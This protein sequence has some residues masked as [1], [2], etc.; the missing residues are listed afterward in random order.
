MSDPPEPEGLPDAAPWEA[1]ARAVLAHEG[2]PADAEVS[3]RFVDE[4]EMA[5]LNATHLGQQGPTDVLSFPVDLVGLAA[6]DPAPTGDHGP[7]LAGDLVLCLPVARRNAAAS[8]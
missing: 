1:L 7:V 6:G 4:D 3:V 5:G 8:K 2:A